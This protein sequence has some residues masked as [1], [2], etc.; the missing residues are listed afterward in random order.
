MDALPIH[1]DTKG[2]PVSR[3]SSQT[4]WASVWMSLVF[5]A[6]VASIVSIVSH[7][8]RL[9]QESNSSIQGTDGGIDSMYLIVNGKLIRDAEQAKS[10]S[11]H[12]A[13]IFD[14][15]IIQSKKSNAFSINT[16]NRLSNTSE[17][18]FKIDLQPTDFAEKYNEPLLDIITCF[19]EAHKAVLTRHPKIN[20]YYFIVCVSASGQN[21][22]VE[23]E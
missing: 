4:F 23:S 8:P 9:G 19:R 21:Q 5:V 13:P 14:I 1:S 15:V 10:L 3:G 7:L 20:V 17:S 16:L 22:P 18:I 6:S 11:E 12:K 2:S